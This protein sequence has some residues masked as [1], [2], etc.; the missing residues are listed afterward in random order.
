M[1]V[2]TLNHDCQLYIILRERKGGRE[3]R[4]ERGGGR[5]S[6]VV[7]S[8]VGQTSSES[9]GDKAGGGFVAVTTT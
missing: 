5:G 1:L 8:R 2:G 7:S 6:D 4:G 3:R 9:G